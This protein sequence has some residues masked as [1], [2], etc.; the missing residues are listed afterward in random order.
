MYSLIKGYFSD[1]ETL[2][3]ASTKAEA[4]TVNFIVHVN[5]ASFFVNQALQPELSFFLKS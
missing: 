4:D 2:T 3:T 1:N 5:D